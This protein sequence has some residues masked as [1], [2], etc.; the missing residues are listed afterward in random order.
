M[1]VV[2]HLLIISNFKCLFH[3]WI[4]DSHCSL[5]VRTR[6]Q[7]CLDWCAVG[8][9]RVC[10]NSHAHVC[11]RRIFDS[12]W[13]LRVVRCCQ[14]RLWHGVWIVR[15][16]TSVGECKAPKS[17]HGDGYHEHARVHVVRNRA[18][19]TYA[20][21]P[22]VFFLTHKRLLVCSSLLH[23]SR[24][25]LNRFMVSTLWS[26]LSCSRWSLF[27]WRVPTQTSW[28]THSTLRSTGPRTSWIA[29]TR[30]TQPA[31]QLDQFPQNNHSAQIQ[32]V[33]SMRARVCARAHACVRACVCVCVC[34]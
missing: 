2:D 16:T 3:F 29:N 13:N 20:H 19:Y 8:C 34:L 27:R 21:T 22:R 17:E 32:I 1:F 7:V 5:V 6:T 23:C 24:T 15:H 33:Q 12:V 18:E 11:S 10:C 30:E 4:V 26:C 28:Q 31:Q 14:R 25:L 9:G